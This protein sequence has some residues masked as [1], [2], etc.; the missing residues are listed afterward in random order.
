MFALI[1][2]IAQAVSIYIFFLVMYIVITWL[3]HFNV[4]NRSNGLV[5]MLDDIGK[6]VTEPGLRPLRRLQQRMFPT[7]AIDLSPIALILLLE[8]AVNLMK[9]LAINAAA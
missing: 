9:E 7:M 3:I 8:F 1:N 5:R 2:L 4:L 6:S